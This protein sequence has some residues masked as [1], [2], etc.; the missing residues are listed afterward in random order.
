MAKLNNE[1]LKF[2]Y[3]VS[4]VITEDILDWKEYQT[5]IS[6]ADN[7]LN[8]AGIYCKYEKLPKEQ[9]KYLEMLYSLVTA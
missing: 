9:K 6:F 8:L 1:N 4:T 2:H 3:L 7:L 5:F